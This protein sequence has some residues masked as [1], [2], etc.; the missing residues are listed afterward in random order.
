[1]ANS[2]DIV[3]AALATL[4]ATMTGMSSETVHERVP[5]GLQDF[6][7][8]LLLPFEGENEYESFGGDELNKTHRIRGVVLSA[9]TSDLAQR[10]AELTPFID[11][12]PDVLRTS[13]DLGLGTVIAQPVTA[14]PYKFVDF[15]YNSVNHFA[16][17]WTIE[18]TYYDDLTGD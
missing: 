9:P 1:M 5:Q 12:V 18:A 14:T 15:V 17:E 4:F 2:F 13:P 8:M 16:V 3:R 6:P 7:C 11:R 10:D